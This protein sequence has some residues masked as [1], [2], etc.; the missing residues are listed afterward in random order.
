MYSHRGIQH[1]K[2]AFLLLLLLLE[3]VCLTDVCP[4]FLVCFEEEGVLVG[5]RMVVLYYLLMH[6]LQI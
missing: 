2:H 4:S 1:V 3:N 6:I 5:G